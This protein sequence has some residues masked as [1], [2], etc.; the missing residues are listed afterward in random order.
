MSN[1]LSDN[2]TICV[3]IMANVLSELEQMAFTNKNWEEGTSYPYYLYLQAASTADPQICE[4]C[5]TAA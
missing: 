1:V 2:Y 3:L 4:R 5:G